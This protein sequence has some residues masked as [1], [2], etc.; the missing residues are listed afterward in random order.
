MIKEREYAATAQIH[1]RTISF[2]LI[3]N[4]KRRRTGSSDREKSR[5]KTRE[6]PSTGDNNGMVF[7]SLIMVAAMFGVMIS[8]TMGLK[9]E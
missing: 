2:R 4:S 1:Q 9:E 5:Q 3:I 8:V 7:W 6:L